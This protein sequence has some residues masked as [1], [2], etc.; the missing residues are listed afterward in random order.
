MSDMDFDLP[1]DSEEEVPDWL[2]D[3]GGDEPPQAAGASE[4]E[5]SDWIANANDSAPEP[6][7]TP[8]PE[9][10]EDSDWPSGSETEATSVSKSPAGGK[11]EVPDWLSAG[12]SKD[13][14]VSAP[15]STGEEEVPDWLSNIR[16]SEAET[17]PQ[18]DSTTAGEETGE[19]KEAGEGEEAD[20]GEEDSQWLEQIREAE[21]ERVVS[22]SLEDQEEAVF[23]D[24]IQSEEGDEQ[25]AA[26]G[27]E[28][29][30]TPDWLSG[31]QSEQDAPE[32]EREQIPDPLS[33]I[34]AEEPL[35]EVQETIP[36]TDDPVP[37][38]NLSELRADRDNAVE[39]IDSEFPDLPKDSGF[40]DTGS[41]PSWLV[42]MKRTGSL[43]E[44]ALPTNAAEDSVS[45]ERPS[46][47]A[48]DE[49]S[50]ELDLSLGELPDWISETQSEI[51]KEDDV[52]SPQGKVGADIGPAEV[53][54]WLH[55]MRPVE[56]PYGEGEDADGVEET[57]G[58]LSGLQDVLPAEPEITQFGKPP[59]FS[60]NLE[61]TEN[62]QYNA[63][64]L[65][66]MIA[67][68]SQPKKSGAA[69]IALTQGA[70]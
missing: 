59:A 29:Q 63:A 69:A 36:K 52:I 56:S 60:L 41:L 65:D 11:E 39:G 7:D 51:D 70:L 2:K 40:K 32:S 23:I 37:D 24:N 3:L 54:T 6:S 18:P 57:I 28:E 47:P 43:E 17:D 68:D 8:S 25:A 9:N 50:S 44:S 1:S 38:E 42:D 66:R 48:A 20:E 49:D 27:V 46:S 34:V 22:E 33:D 45:E 58:P 21:S 19:G 31:M 12:E 67:T 15:T 13:A 30:R 55:S 35:P 4:E 64:L 61:T 62:Q 53:P 14:S 26:D 10:V 16:S 5:T